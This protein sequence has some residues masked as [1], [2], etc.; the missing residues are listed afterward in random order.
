M[1]LE[2]LSVVLVW[3]LSTWI[4]SRQ[5]LMALG[6]VSLALLAV[7]VWILPGTFK[8]MNRDGAMEQIAEFSSWRSAIPAAANV[9][10]VPAHNS[11]AFAWFTLERPSY[12]TVDQSS[13]VVFSRA[14]SLEVRRRSDVL[15][16]LVDP[17]WRLLSGMKRSHG[18]GAGKSGSSS[19]AAG[20]FPR[21]LTRD[22]L[23]SICRDPQLSFVVAK[24]NVGFGA[25][26]H[27]HAG[28]WKDWYLYDCRRVIA[29]TPAA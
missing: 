23:M 4:R 9:F 25:L 19:G 18:S 15:L 29:G 1:G 3:S 5:S 2:G 20:R 14:T 28:D 7:T 17:D 8:D 27:G 22:R 21:P 12:L 16:P 6:A 11:A 10:V 24:E 26:G 13:G